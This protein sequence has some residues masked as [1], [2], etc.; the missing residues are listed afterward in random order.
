M[1]NITAAGR[2]LFKGL[3]WLLSTTVAILMV[4]KRYKTGCQPGF[5]AQIS[6]DLIC[7]QSL[8]ATAACMTDCYI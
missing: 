5:K 7:I 6:H 2:D 8:Q 3:R 1:I 4:Y